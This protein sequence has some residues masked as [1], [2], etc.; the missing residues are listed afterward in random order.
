MHYF[1]LAEV[2]SFGIASQKNCFNA[3]VPTRV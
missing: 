2:P 1:R 3:G